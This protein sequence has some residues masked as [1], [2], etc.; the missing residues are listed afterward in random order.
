MAIS[1][2][3][4]SQGNDWVQVRVSGLDSNYPTKSLQY[5]IDGSYIDSYDTTGGGGTIQFVVENLDSNTSYTLEVRAFCYYIVGGLTDW[6]PDP[7]SGENINSITIRTSSGGGGGGTPTYVAYASGDSIEI[8]IINYGSN[9]QTCAYLFDS[10]S[11]STQIDYKYGNRTV[12]FSGL[13][14]GTYYVQVDYQDD[15]ITSWTTLQNDDTGQ[16]RTRVEVG[17]GGTAPTY[18]Y[19][20]QGTSVIFTVSNRGNYYLD[21]YVRTNYS[22]GVNTTIYSSADNGYLETVNT[23]TVSELSYDVPYA[24]NV[25]YSTS[26][27][28]SSGVTW[29]GAQ[30]FTLT[31]PQVGGYVYI[32]NGSRWVR[33]KPYIFNGNRWM[34]AT[35]YIF[36]G[37]R[38]RQCIAEN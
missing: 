34:P 30:Y 8:E 7:A 17:G 16:T 23:K 6:W 20:T 15:D 33:A 35:P 31:A 37:S 4:I 22:S 3:Q 36:D 29:I 13:S 21:Y 5:Y 28:P 14:N 10:A 18:T 9:C 38:W 19:E 2:T 11:A 27:D 1:I 25:G 26:S 24:I 32:F 12:S